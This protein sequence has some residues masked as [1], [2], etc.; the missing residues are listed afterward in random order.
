MEMTGSRK[1][2]EPFRTND[3]RNSSIKR[4]QSDECPESSTSPSDCQKG[5]LEKSCLWILP[6]LTKPIFT[7]LADVDQVHRACHLPESLGQARLFQGQ[8]WGTELTTNRFS[9]A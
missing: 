7:R 8:D 6:N 3:I 2:K 1:N 5:L 9:P 4:E